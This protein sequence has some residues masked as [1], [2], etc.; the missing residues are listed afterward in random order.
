[1][2]IK[3]KV[4]IGILAIVV[5][6]TLISGNFLENLLF[7]GCYDHNGCQKNLLLQLKAIASIL[8]ITLGIGLLLLCHSLKHTKESL[9]H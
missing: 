9:S 5:G 1:M 8:L 6:V 3:F 2:N 7:Q 4:T